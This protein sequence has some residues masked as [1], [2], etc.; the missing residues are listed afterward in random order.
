MGTLREH[1]SDKSLLY[2]KQEARFVSTFHIC[3]IG[4]EAGNEN[5]ARVGDLPP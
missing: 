2:K 1:F 3:W 4:A 5:D